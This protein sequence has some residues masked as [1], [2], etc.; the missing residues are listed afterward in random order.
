MAT[1][2]VIPPGINIPHGYYEVV[3]GGSV[4]WQELPPPKL[5]TNAFVFDPPGQR[6][7]LG[8]K[9]RGFGKD[10]YGTLCA[11]SITH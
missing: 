4:P 9:K 11:V 10:M 8:Y 7:L 1:S 3:S 5:F 2:R 6:I